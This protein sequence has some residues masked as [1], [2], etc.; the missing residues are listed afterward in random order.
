M[1][2]FDGF[3]TKKDLDLYTITSQEPVEVMMPMTEDR[4]VMR[5]SLLNGVLDAVQY[6]RARKLEDLQFF[7]IGKVYSKEKEELKLDMSNKVKILTYQ[8]NEKEIINF[9]IYSVFHIN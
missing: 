7:E 6:N 1:S 9:N 8:N 3:E 4:A 2:N 5:Q